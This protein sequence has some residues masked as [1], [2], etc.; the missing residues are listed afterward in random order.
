MVNYAGIE[1]NAATYSDKNAVQVFGLVAV[2]VGGTRLA[3][4][5]SKAPD[6]RDA[7]YIDVVIAAEGLDEGEVDLQCNVILVLLV[8]SQQ[9]Q[10]N[11]VRVAA[12]GAKGK[13]TIN[14]LFIPL[15]GSW[16]VTS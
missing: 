16:N 7:Q 14:N 8:H 4:D 9:A 5:L 13:N 3:Q 15:C 10:N 2:V 6:A 11:T 1:W 12:E